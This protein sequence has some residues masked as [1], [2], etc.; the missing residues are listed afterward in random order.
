MDKDSG[1]RNSSGFNT[2]SYTPNGA[3]YSNWVEIDL[4]AI[5]N[6]IRRLRAQARTQVMAVLKANGYGHGAVPVAQ[7]ALRAG[8]AWCGVARLEEALELRRAGLDCPIL[9]LGYT[10]TGRYAEAIAAGISLAAWD[11]SQV[12]AAVQAAGRVGGAAR[13]HLKVDT[14]MSRLGTQPEGALHVA[15]AM[16][17]APRVIFEGLFTHFARADEPASASAEQQLGQFRQVLA[18][19]EAAGLRPPLVHAANSAAIFCRPE[20]SFDLVRAGIAMYGLHPSPDC[21]LPPG[22]RPALAWKAV[23]SQVKTLP[24]GRGVSYGHEYVTRAVE[25]IGTLPVGYAD[26]YRRQ[27][28]NQVL[29]HG[30]RAPVVGRVCMDQVLVQL[31]GLPEARE[32]DEAVLIGRQGEARLP[33]EELGARWGTVNYEVVCGISPRV[34]RVYLGEEG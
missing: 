5:E 17:A 12:Q 29:I 22:F 25:R 24:P 16:A 6:N 13:L 15:R 18:G 26:G 32:G 14:G 9:I 19:I 21:R 3:A 10:P 33:A 1:A 28:S 7:A 27:T 34:P 11:D 4:Q 30:A 31:D 2:L 8:A 23:L 20:A